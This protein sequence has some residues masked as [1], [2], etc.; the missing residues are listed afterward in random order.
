MAINTE[1]NRALPLNYHGSS[2]PVHTSSFV[3]TVDSIAERDQYDAVNIIKNTSTTVSV[4]VTGNGGILRS[5]YL[6]G[7]ISISSSVTDVYGTGTSF[8]TDFQVGDII[9]T[10]SGTRRIIDIQSDTYL[11][12]SR[13]FSATNAAITY[14]RGDRAPSTFYN[15]YVIASVDGSSVDMCLSTR[16]VATGDALVD[17]PA[18]YTYYRQL[19]LSIRTD[20]NGSGNGIVNFKVGAGWPYRPVIYNNINR[21]ETNFNGVKIFSGTSP[22]TATLLSCVDSEKPEIPVKVS[23][24]G[25]FYVW[26]TSGTHNNYYFLEEG[27]T[28]SA[29]TAYLFTTGLNSQASKV[30]F[31]I[32]ANGNFQHISSDTT[33]A[34]RS[35]YVAGYIITE[36]P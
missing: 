27:E 23:R 9:N 31:P 19:P 3:V 14:R 17:L 10:S 7:T 11:I 5:N 34:S 21:A 25:L 6:A 22:T 26:Q 2:S 8:L 33:A 18:G 4:A 1:N 30:R 36:V 20:D 24:I 16:S 13:V 15:L 12:V 28:F 35:I 29:S 32:S